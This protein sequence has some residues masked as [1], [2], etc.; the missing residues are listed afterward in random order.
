MS[1]GHDGTTGPTP[2]AEDGTVPR[3][4]RTLLLIDERDT[5]HGALRSV[6]AGDIDLITVAPD[7]EPRA[8]Y[9]HHLPDAIIAVIPAHGGMELAGRLRELRTA[10]PCHVLIVA[11][12]AASAA[13]VRAWTSHVVIAP[14][15]AAELGEAVVRALATAGPDR[16]TAPTAEEEA[17]DGAVDDA[18][19]ARRVPRSDD[20]LRAGP[21][22][23]DTPRHEARCDGQPLSLTR[24]EFELLALFVRYPDQ[25]LTRAQLL[26]NVWGTWT[27]NDHHVDVHLSRLRRKIERAAGVAALPAVR[28]VGFRL[29]GSPGP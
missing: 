9:A 29:L 19:M 1:T 8:A 13:T 5:L 27:G 22:E 24:I 14:S 2:D 12:N 15:T 23:V 11:A 20:P 6:V 10:V 7:H 17:D 25:V 28:G 16:P 18:P 26:A 21:F 3:W 4:Y